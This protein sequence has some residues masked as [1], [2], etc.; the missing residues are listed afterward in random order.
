MAKFLF[1]LPRFHTNAVPWARI[2]TSSSHQVSVIV[3]YVGPTES[4][5]ITVPTPMAPSRLQWLFGRRR[6]APIDTMPSV[7]QV[8]RRIRND[9]PDVIV[10]RGA[11]RRLSQVAIACALLQGRNF[12]IYDQ[13]DVSPRALSTRMRRAVFRAIGVPHFTARIG[14]RNGRCRISEAMTIPFG[15]PTKTGVPHSE[16]PDRGG[17]PKILMVAKYRKRKGHVQLLDAMAIVATSCRFSLVICGEEASAEDREYCDFLRKHVREVGLDGMVTFCNNVPYEAMADLYAQ[18]DV[19]VLPSRN[20]PAAVSPIEAAWCGCAVL[21]SRD[22]GTRGYLPSGR[23][24]EFDATDPADIARAVIGV[25]SSPD[26]LAAHRESCRSHIGRIASD[27]LI[28][29]RFEWLLSLLCHRNATD[30]A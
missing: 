23:D 26:S 6:A 20:E 29:Q 24:Y 28:L 7:R 19:F 9:A 22:S 13:E 4:H 27:H 25:V 16:E 15:K 5:S 8:W 18:H 12:A 30:A 1:C 3:S 21:V 11:S 10:V 17:P 14:P 2:L